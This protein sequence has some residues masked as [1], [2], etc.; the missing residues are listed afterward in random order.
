MEAW[1]RRPA[2]VC[3]F[4]PSRNDAATQKINSVGSHIR[5]VNR[6]ETFPPQLKGHIQMQLELVAIALQSRLHVYSPGFQNLSGIICHSN[7]NPPNQKE[8]LLSAAALKPRRLRPNAAEF[9]K[10]K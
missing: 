1:E 5:K 2:S 4:Q 8:V 10:Q 6:E 9:Y 7:V 3:S